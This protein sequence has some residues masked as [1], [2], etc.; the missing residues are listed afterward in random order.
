M[1]R[2][3][4]EKII[5]K[6]SKRPIDFKNAKKIIYQYNR[7]QLNLASVEYDDNYSNKSEKLNNN[8]N[9]ISEKNKNINIKGKEI[10]E[11]IPDIKY[12]EIIVETPA[13]DLNKV[14]KIVNN[15][16]LSIKPSINNF[17]NVK[18]EE[19]NYINNNF[20]LNDNNK[21]KNNEKSINH[22]FDDSKNKI[23][24]NE[25]QIDFIG[26]NKEINSNQ[27]NKTRHFYNKTENIEL[28]KILERTNLLSNKNDNKFLKKNYIN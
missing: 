14:S 20:S 22:K 3:E 10:N 1:E 26:T 21:E 27:K 24:F 16:H 23:S 28:E 5:Q 25:I 8:N 6:Y 4:F 9:I 11:N 15:Y 19:I 13:E 2:S 17:E 18:K 12:N 7:N